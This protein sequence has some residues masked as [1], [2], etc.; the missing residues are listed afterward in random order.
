MRGSRTGDDAMRYRLA[1][2][3]VEPNHFVA[4]VLDLPACYSSAPNEAQAISLAPVRIAE[5]LGWLARHEGRTATKSPLEAQVFETFHS[6]PSAR[7]PEYIVNAFFEDDRRPLS[8]DEVAMILRLL[9]WTRADL[10]KLIAPLTAEHLY[11]PINGESLGSI[12]GVLNHIAGAENWY[13]SHLHLGLE[14][15]PA[16]ART[17]LEAVRLNARAQLPQL[18]GDER[19]T[20][21]YDELWSA[22]KVTRRTLWHERDHTQH[23]AQL[24]SRS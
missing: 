20:Q 14:H 7:D 3:D 16:D 13:F 1:V 19:I 15:L 2:E 17:R 24:L 5:H 12:A 9:E 6:Y 21:N 4:Y 18:I 10:L 8:A 22:R 23:L 11:K